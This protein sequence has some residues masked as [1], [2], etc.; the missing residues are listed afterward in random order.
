MQLQW[1]CRAT[2]V[3]PLHTLGSC[4]KFKRLTQSQVAVGPQSPGPGL[5]APN[6]PATS[7]GGPEH[8][9]RPGERQAKGRAR[10]P[11]PRGTPPSQG[12]G[13][14]G[15]PPP[16]EDSPALSPG[17]ADERGSFKCRWTASVYRARP[18]LRRE[19]DSRP[20]LRVFSAVLEAARRRRRREGRQGWGTAGDGGVA[21]PE[22]R[23][24]CVSGRSS[25]SCP[26][27]GPRVKQRPNLD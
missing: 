8:R 21:E 3:T 22:L 19:A 1:L 24:P 25:P 10:S 9:R 4:R 14:A 2:L 7:G 23:P 27:Q 13:E 17:P 5:S 18:S 11:R 15:P 16:K 6:V 12:P 26:R 20:C